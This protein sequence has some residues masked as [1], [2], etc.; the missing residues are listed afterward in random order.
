MKQFC[1]LLALIAGLAA[2]T[3]SAASYTSGNIVVLQCDGTATT[4]NTVSLVEYTP[5]GTMVSSNALPSN[6][7][8]D[9]G[10]SFVAGGSSVLNHD[11]SLSADGALIVIP[12][13]AV[14]AGSSIDAASATTVPRVIAT[15]KYNQVYARPITITTGG[16]VSA[17]VMRGAS[18]DGFGNF[19]AVSGGGNVAYATSAST[20]ASS[21]TGATGRGVGA[22]NGNL[23]YTAAPTG[24]PFGAFAFA[25]MPTTTATASI[26]LTSA[27]LTQPAGF[28]MQNSSAVGAKA[29][30]CNYN[31]A[32]KVGIQGFTF[33]GSSWAADTAA[34]TFSSGTGTDRPQHIAVDYSG[35]N[36]V[37]YFTVNANS[38]TVEIGRMRC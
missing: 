19:W 8:T 24:G 37:L 4:G 18:S 3:A 2:S 13:Y 38:T 21:I 23:A 10:T 28:S 31:D 16:A 14:T 33:N 20:T 26:I 35:I 27:F 32:A 5:A 29:Y 36:P 34:I 12:G 11:M 22:Y 7:G 1:I 30:I 15:M 9:N 6:G 25:G 17:N